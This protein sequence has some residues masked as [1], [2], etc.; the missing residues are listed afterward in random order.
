MAGLGLVFALLGAAMLGGFGW[1]LGRC[2]AR[3]LLGRRA[4]V[5]ILLPGLHRE[6]RRSDAE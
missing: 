3:W 2:A 1:E 4:D 6:R 5:T